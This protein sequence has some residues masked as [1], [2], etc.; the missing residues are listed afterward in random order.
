MCSIDSIEN[1]VKANYG[2][3]FSAVFSRFSAQ[4]KVSLRRAM[5]KIA[6]EDLDASMLIY[7]SKQYLGM[8]KPAAQPLKPAASSFEQRVQSDPKV[9][10]LKAKLNRLLAAPSRN[11]ST[12]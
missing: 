3:T 12:A 10:E 5:W 9:Q 6:V 1:K 2:E 11:K 8:G 4:K 7:L